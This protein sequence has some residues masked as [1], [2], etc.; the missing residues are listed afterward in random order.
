MFRV[1]QKVTMKPELGSM[2]E[3]WTDGLVVR[4]SGPPDPIVGEVYTIAAIHRW[5]VLYL[6]LT[7][8]NEYIDGRVSHYTAGRF[9]PVTSIAVFERL[10]KSEPIRQHE[11]V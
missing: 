4:T 10:L 2:W 5:G 3:M 11:R 6:Q 8:I 9:R 7:E 1:G